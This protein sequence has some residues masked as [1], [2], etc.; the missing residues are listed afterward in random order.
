MIITTFDFVGLC[1]ASYYCPQGRDV[2]TPAQFLCLA[3]HYCP[4][5]SAVSQSCPNGTFS[6]TTGNMELAN[7]IDCTSGALFS[8][9]ARDL[10]QRSR[11]PRYGLKRSRCSRGNNV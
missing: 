9:D 6:N 10:C 2:A 8:N 4:Q 5:G 7:C 3:G 1:D 11:R